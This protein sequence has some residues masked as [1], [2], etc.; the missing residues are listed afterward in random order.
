MRFA[1]GAW[2]AGYRGLVCIVALGWDTGF[3]PVDARTVTLEYI[4]GDQTDWWF[5]IKRGKTG[6]A[7]IGTLR[8]RT[9][10]IIH[11]YVY[12]LDV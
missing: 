8:L 3:A 6:K 11:A 7:A 12:G 10:H 4:L 5:F 1:K 2:R 9:R